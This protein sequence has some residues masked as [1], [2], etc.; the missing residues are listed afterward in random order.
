[1]DVTTSTLSINQP[2]VI[3]HNSKLLIEYYI[4]H[5][6]RYYKNI[7]DANFT[8]A[9][10]KDTRFI[11]PP[12]IIPHI[13]ISIIECNPKTNIITDKNTIQTQNKLTHIYEDAR[14]HL[15]TMPTT[16]LK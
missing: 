13:Q 9:Q 1:M 5:Q 10:N 2:L 4:K 12:I 15:I 3:E 14:R 6:H 11:P 16:R 7:L 8:P